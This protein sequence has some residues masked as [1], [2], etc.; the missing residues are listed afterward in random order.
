[1]KSRGKVHSAFDPYLGVVVAVSETS[2]YR[3]RAKLA[4]PFRWCFCELCWRPTEHS[5]T[6]QGPT[7]VKRLQGGNAKIVP[8]TGAIDAAAKKRADAL[9]AHYERACGG[10]LGPFE[11]G[12][13]LAKYCDIP[14]LRGDFS[15]ESFRDHVE[16]LARTA[17]RARHGDL[18]RPTRL[19]N[20]T[21]KDSKPSIFYCEHHNPKRSDDARRAYQRDR[22]FAAE[23]ENQIEEIWSYCNNHNKLATW[24][25]DAHQYVREE[26]YRLLR[27]RKSPSPLAVSAAL[28]RRARRRAAH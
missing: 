14:D 2:S 24:D 21:D 20:H 4:D 1:M 15:V 23:Y 9:V 18:L 13:M 10:E 16:M 22:R 26:A 8:L 3:T 25:L 12:R 19:P 28:K 17:E 27:E 11:P 5:T 7:V 6:V